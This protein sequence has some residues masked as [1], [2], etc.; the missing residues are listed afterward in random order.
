MLNVSIL[1]PPGV[2]IKTNKDFSVIVAPEQAGLNV[3]AKWPQMILDP[4]VLQQSL[5][6]GKKNKWPLSKFNGFRRFVNRLRGDNVRSDG[7]YTTAY[8]GLPL[9]V[10]RK[11]AEH[12]RILVKK[13]IF[14]VH[15]SLI[16]DIVDDFSDEAEFDVLHFV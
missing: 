13:S 4:S 9:K 14:V 8:I 6:E 16:V 5:V 11:F 7:A 12:D 15:I 1:V 3:T 2:S 10:N